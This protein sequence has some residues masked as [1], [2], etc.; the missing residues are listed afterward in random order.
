[1][2]NII[3]GDCYEVIKQL[4][5]KSIQC[6]VCSPPYF[7]LR[8]YEVPGQIGEE[9]TPE[10]YA[11][12]IVKVFRE[13]R[14]VLTDD[15]VIWVNIGDTFAGGGGYCPNAPSNKAGS[16]QSHNRGSLAKP[17]PIP[18]GSK[19]KDLLCIPFITAMALKKDGWYFRCDCI[20]QKTNC[21]PE[22]VTD[23]PTRV[24]EYVFLFS[25]KKKYYYDYEAIKE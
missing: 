22:N 9:S 11:E 17:R 16:L 6:V 25:K 8:N 7:Q 4:P 24:H 3:E 14:N 15:G 13:V 23:R 20:W 21:S 10:I 5:P 19:A 12:S 1:M 18:P 2:W